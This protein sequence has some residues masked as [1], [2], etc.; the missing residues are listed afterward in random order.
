MNGLDGAML[1]SIDAQIKQ[2]TV[3]GGGSVKLEEGEDSVKILVDGESVQEIDT[4]VVLDLDQSAVDIEPVAVPY[5]KAPGTDTFF[6]LADIAGA[7]AEASSFVD[8]RGRFTPDKVIDGDPTSTWRAAG[9]PFPGEAAGA[10]A[11]TQHWITINFGKEITLPAVEID[12][13]FQNIQSYQLQY[14]SGEEWQTIH[15]G[16][17]LGIGAVLAFKPVTTSEIRLHVLEV[18]GVP[19]ISEIRVLSALE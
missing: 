10:E 7:T 5:A 1:P 6:R 12:E 15:E 8:S 3:L 2:A 4:I 18:E 19:H 17:A 11:D 9:Y 14:R 13:P 16:D